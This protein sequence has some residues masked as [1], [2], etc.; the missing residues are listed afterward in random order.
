MSETEDIAQAAMDA[1]SIVEDMLE[2]AKKLRKRAEKLEKESDRVR[3]YAARDLATYLEH[4][5]AEIRG[6]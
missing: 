5:A 6:A 2:I 1:R 4:A 3:A